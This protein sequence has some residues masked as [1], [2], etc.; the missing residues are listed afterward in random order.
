MTL[1]IN[2]YI[3]NISGRGG[4]SSPAKYK[5]SFGGPGPGGDDKNVSIMCNVSAL[6]GKSIQTIENRHFNNPFKLPYAAIYN[7]ITFTFLST[8]GFSERR[9][10]SIW[11]NK[12]VH[13]ETGLIGFYDWYK[14]IITIEHLDSGTGRTDYNVRLFNAYPMDI[15]E[16]PLGYSMANETINVGVSFSYQYWDFI[17]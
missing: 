4:I 15:G 9:F 12:V 14:G 8:L 1:A 2:E 10:F 13:P 7:E 16:I 11:M 17:H 5:V 6:P 3:S